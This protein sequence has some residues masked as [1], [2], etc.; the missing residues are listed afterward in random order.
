MKEFILL[1]SLIFVA[2]IILSI[3]Q[4]PIYIIKMGSNNNVKD[5]FKK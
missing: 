1:S 5:S 3:D 2:A 4:K